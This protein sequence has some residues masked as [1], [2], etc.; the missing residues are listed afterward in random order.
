MGR[1]PSHFSAGQVSSEWLGQLLEVTK[2]NLK[3]RLP[4][5]SLLL[6]SP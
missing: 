4:T 3:Q 2:H 6:L 5:P 1:D